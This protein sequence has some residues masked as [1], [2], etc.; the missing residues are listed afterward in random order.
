M[1]LFEAVKERFSYRGKFQNITV[2]EEDL[3]KIV[4]AA[5]DAPSGNN[6]QTTRFII[7]NDKG[8]IQE[9]ASV[10]EKEYMKTAQAIIVFAAEKET[11]YSIEDC[12]A[13]VENALLAVTAL[14]YT[15]VWIDGALRRKNRAETIAAFV[16]VPNQFIVRVILPLGRPA[17]PPK[18]KTKKPFSE[19]AYFN[20]M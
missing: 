3:K 8:L 1:D 20:S 18:R 10:V 14:G 5:M 6:L 17:E 11:A 15:S 9:I 2:P 12:A 4:Q 13:A 7:V 16:N 19:R